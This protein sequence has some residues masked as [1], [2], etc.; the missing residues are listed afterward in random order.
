M[1]PITQAGILASTLLAIAAAGFVV[2]SASPEPADATPAA[3]ADASTA[4]EETIFTWDGYAK[5][6]GANEVLAHLSDTEAL[7][8]PVWRTGFNLQVEEVPESVE[9]R[10]DW[11]SGTPSEV[12]FMAH[13]PY[14]AARPH[15]WIEF[16]THHQQDARWATEGPLC[17]RI[18]TAEVAPGPWH[19]MAHSRYG[20][21]I[22]IAFTITMI[23]GAA[24]IP[25]GTHGHAATIEEGMTLANAIR[26][27]PHEWEP[28]ATR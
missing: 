26:D 4:R 15:E 9:I 13:V 14:D 6:G 1:S 2:T 20:L 25:E 24:S 22:A 27:G 12:M 19:V 7:V 21:D 23:G 5:A 11:S 18:P 28:C 8:E 10:V 17:M 16:E 3:A